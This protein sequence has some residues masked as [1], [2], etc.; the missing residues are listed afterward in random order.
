M[1]TAAPPSV[2]HVG[3][4]KTASTYLQTAVFPRVRNAQ[5]L[6]RPFTQLNHAFNKMQ[7]ADD[8]RYEADE[9]RR[10]LARFDGR[11]L[12]VSDEMFTGVPNFN[13]INRAIIAQRLAAVLPDARIV[14][15]LRGQRS[16]VRSLHNAWVKNIGG[17][18]PLA[19]FVHFPGPDYHFSPDAAMPAQ[20]GVPWSGTDSYYF[21]H[22]RLTLH[23]SN[24]EYLP[25]VRLY[26]ELFSD[27]H[28][29]LF[30]DYRQDPRATLARLED[31]T[32]LDF[33][34]PEAMPDA[35]NESI[36]DDRLTGWRWRN[37]LAN[38]TRNER[39]LRLAMRFGRLAHRVSATDT[40]VL[41]ERI[42]AYYIDDNRA[43]AA[44][45]P[46]LGLERFPDDYR[47]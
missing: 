16:M 12:L 38:I 35:V 33:A 7:Y 17:A 24:L 20:P 45:R 40:D 39:L 37:S 32:G 47:M 28:V 22:D 18:R 29:V 41:E 27:V 30:E 46:D 19:E 6:T 25:L 44:A 15:F 31:A 14:L 10:E 43:L 26:E 5:L 2:I 11:T 42:A 9:L 23:A 36:T 1:N 4:H 8:T 21:V 34:L 13:Y 3:L